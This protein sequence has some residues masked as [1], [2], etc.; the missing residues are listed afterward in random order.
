VLHAGDNIA[1]SQRYIFLCNKDSGHRRELATETTTQETFCLTLIG[2]ASLRENMQ[3]A[4]NKIEG[5]AAAVT[6]TWCRSGN[7]N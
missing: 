5:R 3:V 6:T 1:L 4:Y 7:N 2:A